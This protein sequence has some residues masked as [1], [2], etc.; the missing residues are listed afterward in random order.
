MRTRLVILTLAL[1]GCGNVES[2]PAPH[3]VPGGG[4]S[5]GAIVGLMNVY[6]TDE[7]TRAPVA[8]AS[9]R[10]GPS[11]SAA[12]CSRLTDPTGLAIFDDQNCPSLKGKQTLT[13]SAAGYLPNT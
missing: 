2:A 3:L 7:D 10:V 13:A 1:L 5:A 6:V 4:I 11:A 12:P 9:V 8:G